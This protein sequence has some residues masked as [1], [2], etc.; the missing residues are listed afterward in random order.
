MDGYIPASI[1]CEGRPMP[2]I[3]ELDAEISGLKSD[4]AKN[5]DPRI[6][7]VEHLE[8]VRA[9]YLA[10]AAEPPRPGRAL[11]RLM[12]GID[13]N[14]IATTPASAGTLRILPRPPGRK[15]SPER[16]RA[17]SSARWLL[18]GKTEPI[19]TAEIHA[20]LVKMGHALG[21]DDPINNLGAMLSKTP[22]FQ[23]HGRSGWTF[24]QATTGSS[25][26]RV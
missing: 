20:H 3:D 11:E 21:G 16:E 6:L 24:V 25:A 22:G 5:P 26:R 14:T 19:K 23:S 9:M 12:S 13:E 18:A 17:R 15:P 4:I 10:G 2:V 8:K 1:N 7:K